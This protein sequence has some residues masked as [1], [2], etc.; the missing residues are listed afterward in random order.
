MAEPLRHRQTKGAATDMFSL[1]PPRYIST[2]PISRPSQSDSA[3]PG[4]ADF[5]AKRFC[6]SERAILIQDQA[7]MRKVDSKILRRERW[8]PPAASAGSRGRA[9]AA[10]PQTATLEHEINQ[11]QSTGNNVNRLSNQ[12]NPRSSPTRCFDGQRSTSTA[13]AMFSASARSQH[14]PH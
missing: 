9:P 6:A 3:R 13:K 11:D 7:P 12:A 4:C 2:L 10:R 5:V 8:L 14:E 1:Q